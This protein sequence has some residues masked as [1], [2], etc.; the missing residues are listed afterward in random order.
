VD[1]V[2]V[3]KFRRERWLNRMSRSA[4]YSET[5]HSHF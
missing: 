4:D 3:L 2:N 5:R 1:G